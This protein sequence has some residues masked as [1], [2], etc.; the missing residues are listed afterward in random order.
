[1][2]TLTERHGGVSY[3]VRHNCQDPAV[4]FDRL[5]VQFW[6]GALPRYEVRFESD[7]NP[8]DENVI[9]QTDHDRGI[10]TINHVRAVIRLKGGLEEALRH[11]LCHVSTR[12]EFEATGDAHGPRFRRELTRVS[13]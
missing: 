4:I 11:E 3:T 9:A 1:M 10:V 2:I 5:N 13:R 12:A 6:D 7:D 8:L